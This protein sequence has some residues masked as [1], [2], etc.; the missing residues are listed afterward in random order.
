MDFAPFDLPCKCE[1]D[2]LDKNIK[3]V[4]EV[5]GMTSRLFYH[6]ETGAP[7]QIIARA[8]TKPTY[9]EV[10]CYQELTEPY[11]HFVMEKR[12]FFAEYVKEFTEL[13]L[14]GRK[15]IEK[16]QDL[17]DRQ[18]R[19]S[20]G[21]VLAEEEPEDEEPENDAIQ[22]MLAFLDAETYHQKIRI[23]ES[24]K[25]ELDEHILNNLAVSLDLSLEDGVDGYQMILSE[26][27]IREKFESDRGDRL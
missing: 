12:Q 18:P 21:E 8:Q 24:M 9:Q 11:D 25:D 2:I 22:R 1:Y 19:I 26:L 20:K 23:L 7:V 4:K 5:F 17:P 14:V 3:Y 6:K 16:R 10:I 27:K 13:P 15:Q